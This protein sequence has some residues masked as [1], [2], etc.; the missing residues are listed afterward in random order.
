MFNVTLVELCFD[1]NFITANVKLM[2][3]MQSPYHEGDSKR[4]KEVLALDDSVAGQTITPR[5]LPRRTLRNACSRRCT[6]HDPANHLLGE[7][8]Q[9]ASSANQQR[10]GKHHQIQILRPSHT[11]ARAASPLH[12]RTSPFR[13]RA[14]AGQQPAP[15]ASSSKG[16][17]P[18]C[19][20]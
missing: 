20:T 16:L 6:I 1:S 11:A 13:R 7:R 15:T 5:A 17:G 12:G 14:A 10:C 8:N 19:T 9:N 18:P 2:K 3:W 4:W